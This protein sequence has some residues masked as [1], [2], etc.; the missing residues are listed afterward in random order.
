MKINPFNSVHKIPYINTLIKRID[1]DIQ[2]LGF[3]P[4]MQQLIKRTSMALQIHALDNK[5][6]DLLQSDGCIVIFNHPYEIET[7]AVVAALPNRNDLK[8]IATSNLLGISK[9]FDHYLLPVYVDHNARKEKASKL[10][11]RFVKLFN[12][13]P[14]IHP[15]K[16]HEKNIQTLKNASHFI[17]RGGLVLM[18]PEGFRGKGGHWFSGIGHLITGVGSKNKAYYISCY[19][20]HTS[21]LD[22]FRLIPCLGHILP[23]ITVTF[24]NPRPLRDIIDTYRDPKNI[25]LGLEHEYNLW[26]SSLALK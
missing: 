24:S 26:T 17:Q 20:N 12:L 13:R 7:Y 15:E 21:N 16:A 3:I 22:W 2:L 9:A 6:H 11:G 4:A 19:I 8:I 18:C 14:Y 5:T 23:T 10:S 25:A 1:H